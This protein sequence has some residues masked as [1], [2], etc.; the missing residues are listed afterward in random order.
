MVGSVGQTLLG[1]AASDEHH[2]LYPHTPLLW[3]TLR[4]LRFNKL[5]RARCT[6]RF[7][8]KQLLALKQPFVVL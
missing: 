6:V 7:R 2:R 3:S 4:Y 1:C 5:L 8:V